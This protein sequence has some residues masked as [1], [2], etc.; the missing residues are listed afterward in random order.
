MSM[1]HVYAIVD[2]DAIRGAVPLGHDGQPVAA[3][4]ADGFAAV[5]GAAKAGG[6]MPTVEDVWHHDAILG[7]LMAEHVV[8]PLRFGT[9]CDQAEL[10][11]LLRERRRRTWRDLDRVRGR[12]ELALRLSKTVDE[13]LAP[14]PT[15]TAATDAQTQPGTA[16]L[17]TRMACRHQAPAAGDTAIRDI[18]D[19]IDRLAVA[20]AWDDGAW[21]VKASCL[22]ARSAVPGFIDAAER[23]VE[24]YPHISM[25][26][27]GP[28]APYSFVGAFGAHEGTP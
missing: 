19:R 10:S 8:V 5:V 25:S 4:P 1:L 9:L 24:R 15:R 11:G 17:M 6:T 23:L 13:K 2:G 21:P 18:R 14:E 20:T 16:Y 12:V 7:A 26:C 27:T 22:I 3:F 28:W